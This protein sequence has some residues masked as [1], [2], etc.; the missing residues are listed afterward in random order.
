M[1]A[2]VADME[3]TVGGV[4]MRFEDFAATLPT[5]WFPIVNQENFKE[6]ALE[7]ANNKAFRAA[8]LANMGRPK[9]RL[10]SYAV[11]MAGPVADSRPLEQGEG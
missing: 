6:K 8:V 10:R 1:Q 5:W 9:V 3:A 11:S 7:L 4:S 2:A